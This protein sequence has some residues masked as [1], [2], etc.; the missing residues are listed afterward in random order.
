MKKKQRSPAPMQGDLFSSTSL[1]RLAEV[2]KASGAEP[3]PNA[4]TA[5]VPTLAGPKA[6]SQTPKA[7]LAPPV[8][9]AKAVEVVVTPVAAA[10][11]APSPGGPMPIP[12]AQ[13]P[14]PVIIPP[15]APER[16]VVSVSELTRQIKGTLERNFTRVLVRGE[17][18]N[19]RGANARGHLY[20]SLKD[21][22]A[23]V[24][25]KIWASFAQRMKF[26]LREGLA[27]V[28]EGHIDLY[29][30]QGRYS[31]IV[32]K[33]EP[34]G[35]GALALAF[36]QLK[37]RLSA[38]G[39]MGERR[40]RPQRPIPFLPRRIGVVTSKTGAALQDFLRVLHQRHPRLSVLVADAR[41]QGEGSAPEVVR[42]IQR[43]SLTDVDVIVVTRGGGSLEDL[44][45][46]NEES[47]ARAIFACPVPVVSAIGHEVD[48]TIADFVADYRA[49]TPSAAAEKLS[50]VLA[51]LELQLATVK[52]RLHKAVER[53]L[54]VDRS[55]LS[56]QREKLIDPRR[57]LDGRRLELSENAEALSNAIR[58]SLRA[59][60]AKVRSLSERLSRQRPEAKLAQNRQ[61]LSELKQRLNKAMASALARRQDV[62]RRS[63]LT[64]ER[65]N[66]T[67]A[68]RQSRGQLQK[69]HAAVD[70]R[71]KT[72]LQREAH[73][74]QR[75]IEKLEAMSP[76]KVM[77]RGYA[78]TFKPDGHV[79]RKA[80]DVKSGDVIRVRVLPPGAPTETTEQLEDITATVK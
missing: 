44:W 56:L 25:T 18:S 80:S 72:R 6:E 49:P 8:V 47:V 61:R 48:Y 77:S 26:K 17:V 54:L 14:A 46:F 69:L 4:V 13:S 41:V 37:E 53:K 64:I 45:T 74:L 59:R 31:L 29:E 5:S 21:A 35:E 62:L 75:A 57:L 33:I 15:K 66:P 65:R 38:E 43:L 22:E 39:L 71:M 36:Q 11:L 67:A 58:R 1:A 30:P 28:V 2:A 34:E 63:R 70:A 51:E 79:L 9:I 42:A 50:P 20:F 60:E 10:A 19:F 3:P 32:E 52:R 24:D 16:R 40:S 68:I 73:V 76:L 27:V 55:R 78:V 7:L 23:Q 12:V